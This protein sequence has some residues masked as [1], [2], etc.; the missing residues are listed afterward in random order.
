MGLVVDRGAIYGPL[1]SIAL[2]VSLG[3]IGG[4]RLW[5][6]RREY[7]N[8]HGVVDGSSMVVNP[9]PSGADYIGR[10]WLIR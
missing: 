3:W 8:G 1:G 9:F 2:I 6:H 7:G 10:R 5:R 4:R